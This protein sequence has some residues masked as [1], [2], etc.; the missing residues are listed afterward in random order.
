MFGADAS[1]LDR[2]VASLAFGKGSRSAG[3]W[4]ERGR[5]GLF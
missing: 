3:S 1:S 2:R 5:H 4:A